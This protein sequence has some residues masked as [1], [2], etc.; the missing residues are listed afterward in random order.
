MVSCTK[1]STILLAAVA[2]LA[3]TATGALAQAPTPDPAG[4][5]GPTPPRLSYVA[6]G[7]SFW[8]PGAGDWSPAQLNT[9][10]APGDA[11]STGH[12]GN[13]E[14]QV[15][16]RAF[17][18]AWG[19]TQIAL[20]NDDAR[21]LQLT[22]TSGHA[23]LDLRAVDAG[24]TIEIDTPS[25]AF[26][27]TRSGYY[28]A[29][30][31]SGRTSFI[32]RRGGQATLTTASGQA[33]AIAAS[34][35]VVLDAGAPGVET[36]AAPEPDVW[37]RW[38]DA[39]TAHLL[40]ATSARYVSADVYGVSDLDQHGAWRAMPTYGSVW[41]PRAMPGDW[42][43]YS[44]GKWIWD[45]FYGWT[46]VDAA[47]WGWAP[48][49]YGRWVF[50]DGFWGWAPGPRVIRPAYAPALVAFFGTPT[51]D[52]P[53]VSWV[54]LGWGEPVRP[55]WGSATVVGRPWWGG[56]GG[57]RTPVSSYTNVPV[58][59]AVVAMRGEQ[60]ASR[61][62]HEARM[63]RV[64]V[65]RL[66]PVHG[67]LPVTPEPASFVAA[68]G[69]AARPTAAAL[70]P[71]VVA[72]RPAAR[73]AARPV[74]SARPIPAMA[75]P[76]IAT[77]PVIVAPV[78]TS[79]ARSVPAPRAPSANA[80]PPQ[81]PLGPSG[82]ERAPRP[83]PPHVEATPRPAAV[84]APLRADVVP[85]EAMTPPAQNRGLAPEM[86]SG[87]ERSPAREAPAGV[88]RGHAGAP[89]AP[90][91]VP[92]PPASWTPPTPQRVPGPSMASGPRPEPPHAGVRG[93][94]GEPANRLAPGG[95]GVER[96]SGTAPPRAASP[97]PGATGHP[98]H[99]RPRG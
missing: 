50:V 5:G 86:P 70:S 32:T 3:A 60:F 62:V 11:L 71:P 84:P 47:P 65:H 27:V 30:V 99:D 13:V 16:A 75:A 73:P 6:G 95:A 12:D 72:T 37:D 78:T 48:F 23:A 29:D 96:H 21:S 74:E 40:E 49:H 87:R 33:L 34:E 93:L 97:A 77:A 1:R 94:P 63:S 22:L 90:R 88:D 19:D 46:W 61:S 45:P 89:A 25:G 76:A 18:R 53:V 44:T 42:A 92:G 2:L 80:A 85:R 82:V 17:V 41:V 35:D 79:S 83:A 81:Q 28:R 24:R 26:T 10:L 59:H 91:D 39:R 69:R 54:A 43:P 68:T 36:Y 20:A 9:P 15:G 98:E 4:L 7:A 51:I 55:W 31:I 57:P 38:N 8:R 67:R 14:L 64:D 52:A 58:S 66:E 56:W